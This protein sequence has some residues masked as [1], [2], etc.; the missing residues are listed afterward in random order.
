MTC[1]VLC[2]TVESSGM[3]FQHWQDSLSASWGGILALGYGFL[4]SH[5]PVSTFSIKTCLPQGFRYC[6]QKATLVPRSSCWRRTIFIVALPGEGLGPELHQGRGAQGTLGSQTGP[7]LVHTCWV[8]SS[9]TIQHPD[10][11]GLSGCT[12][13][14]F[15]FLRKTIT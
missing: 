15:F 6:C 12:N 8:P 9:I 7:W 2:P 5:F 10:P 3:Y 4:N 13:S 14:I 1:L 11:G